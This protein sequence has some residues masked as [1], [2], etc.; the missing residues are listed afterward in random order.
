M[1]QR[2]ITADGVNGQVEIIGDKLKISRKGVLAFLSQGMKGDK[3]IL[4]SQISSVQFKKAGRLT[5]GYIQFA[6]VGGQ[7]SKGGLFDST[8][9][10]NSVMFNNKQQP[11]FEELKDHLDAVRNSITRGAPA[12]LSELDEL[13]KL[14]SLRDRGILNDEEFEAK[15]KQILGL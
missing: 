3:E 6:F 5:N 12:Q 11:V 15:K 2:T 8:R 4:I 1:H 14:A 10:E 13:E 9:D 7:E